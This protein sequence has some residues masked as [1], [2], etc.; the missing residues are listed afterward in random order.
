MQSENY[1]QI[2]KYSNMLTIKKISLIAATTIILVSCGGNEKTGNSLAEKKAALEKIKSEHAAITTKMNALEAEIAKL[3]TSNANG[4]T[5]KL[6]GLT[7]ITAQPFAHYIDLQGSITSDNVSYVAPRMGPGQVKAIYVKKGD[8][9]KQGQLLLKLDDAVMRQSVYAAQKA[10]ET[11]K[12][13]LSFAKDIYQRQGNLWKEGIG[14]EVQYISAKNNVTSLE[15]QLAAS[16]EQIKVAEEQLKSSNIYADVT[17]VVDDLNVRVGEIFN[18]MAG[19]SPQIKL[20]S[21]AGLKVIT[22]VPEN[23]AGKIKVGSKVI[24]R[25]PDLNKTINGVVATTSRTINTNNRSFD[26]EVHI[27]YDPS[28]RPNQ[29]AELKFQDYETAEAIAISVNTV[30]TDEK[31]KYVYVAVQEGNRMVARKKNITVGEMYGQL[32]EV[33]SG[34]SKNDS[35]ITEGYQNIYD[36]QVV[37]ALKK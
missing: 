33:K 11:L 8:Q 4:S 32:I 15:K 20:V 36:G 5:A 16:E 25:F 9:V 23:Y 29:L 24:I 12:T 26:A 34:L 6:V 27:S 14:T 31:G 37:M 1:N 18:G 35:L 17:G 3:D 10:L 30:Q 13:Q 21:T 7:A 2:K 19:V 28:I 22:Q